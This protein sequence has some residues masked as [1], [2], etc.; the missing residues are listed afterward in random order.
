MAS[1]ELTRL[2]KGIASPERMS[3]LDMIA[4]RPRKHAEIARALD[5]FGSATTRQLR[6]L[7][8]AGLVSR[9]GRGEFELTGVAVAVRRAM[10]YF[11]YLTSHQEYLVRHD[12]SILDPGSIARLGDLHQGEFTTGA[13]QVVATQQAAIREAARR[14]WIIS[15][16]RMD[17]AI[18]LTHRR[19]AK[20]LD[21]RLIRPS[22][23]LA[24]EPRSPTNGCSQMVRTLG[25]TRLFLAVV[26]EF[27]AVCLPHLGGATDLTTM[28]A[29]R[30]PVGVGWA[31]E[32]FLGYWNRAQPWEDSMLALSDPGP[33]RRAEAVH[34]S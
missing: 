21:V 15:E 26:D 24:K 23:A 27:A 10:P 33:V 11:E 9:N 32:V 14:I 16:H 5:L 18:P 12:V 30:D 1:R 2:L 17:E 7:A 20:G 4:A 34:G 8:A 19:G 25:E 3:I 31:E 22:L 6:I 28:I 29:L 13:F